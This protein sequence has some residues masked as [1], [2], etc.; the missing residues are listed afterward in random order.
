MSLE[1]ELREW[2]RQ[3]SICQ[4]VELTQ[5]AADHIRALEAQRT[6]LREFINQAMDLLKLPNWREKLLP[7]VAAALGSAVETE[8]PCPHEHIGN[9]QHQSGRWCLDCGK[10]F[11][12]ATT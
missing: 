5:R 8:A 4:C 6:I 2:T 9:A 7:E 1:Q 11:S 3:E 12:R 10:V